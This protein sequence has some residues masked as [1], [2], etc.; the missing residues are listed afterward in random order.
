MKIGVPKETVPRERRVALTPDAVASLVKDGLEV[1]VEHGAG[2]GAFFDDASYTKAGAT[3]APDAAAL[4]GQADVVAKVQKPTP[5]EVELLREGAVLISFLQALTSPELLQRLAARRVTSFG[6]EGIPRIS[7][8][9][10]MDA[11]SSQANIAGYKAVL[12]AAESLR[13][14]LPI[15]W[16]ALRNG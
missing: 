10:K 1:L 8:A 4:Y 7:R 5:A 16:K 6:M 15:L 11:L 3:I 2:D 14:S 12:L 9:Q 13:K